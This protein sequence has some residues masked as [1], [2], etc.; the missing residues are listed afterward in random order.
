VLRRLDVYANWPFVILL[1]ACLVVGNAIAERRVQA[2]AR[3]AGEAVEEAPV[4]LE[5]VGI[6]TPWTADRLAE[7]DSALQLDGFTAE[8]AADEEDARA[9]A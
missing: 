6:T 4:D 8:M 7:V 5:W 2:R 3:A 1:F 9:R